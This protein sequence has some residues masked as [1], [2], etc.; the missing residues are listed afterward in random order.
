MNICYNQKTP[1]ATPMSPHEAMA[2]ALAEQQ[3][4]LHSN[5]KR[6]TPSPEFAVL[7]TGKIIIIIRVFQLI[8][9]SC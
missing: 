3:S 9:C 2:A 7:S 8:K 5:H 6:E 4:L 1:T